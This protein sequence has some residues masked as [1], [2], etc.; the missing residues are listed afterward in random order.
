MSVD[1]HTNLA[2]DI[3]ILDGCVCVQ[4]DRNE[5]VSGSNLLILWRKESQTPNNK[6]MCIIFSVLLACVWYDSKNGMEL[7]CACCYLYTMCY[8]VMYISVENANVRHPPP[9][10]FHSFSSY[11][12]QFFLDLDLFFSRCFHFSCS[13]LQL[14]RIYS[15]LLPIYIFKCESCLLKFTVFQSTCLVLIEWQTKY[16][17]SFSRSVCFSTEFPFE[18]QWALFTLSRAPQSI[19]MCVHIYLIEMHFS[20]EFQLKL[21]KPK[22]A[23]ARTKNCNL[24]MKWPK[25]QRPNAKNQLNCDKLCGFILAEHRQKAKW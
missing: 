23:H 12:V 13:W 6:Q 5:C 15:P 4:I 8:F 22:I 20:N 14:N 17:R 7:F 9:T 18:W 24:K 16:S 3:S 25:S 1:S 21:K 10:L 2:N 11:C 19:E